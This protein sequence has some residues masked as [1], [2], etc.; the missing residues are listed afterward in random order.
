MYSRE[1]SCSVIVTFDI[2][3]NE[4]KLLNG[5]KV[6]RKLVLT[7]KITLYKFTGRL[8][9]TDIVIDS[10]GYSND[11]CTIILKDNNSTEHE[12]TMRVGTAYVKINK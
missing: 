6:V 9:N 8:S 10:K 2:G 3:K 5:I 1:N 4:I 7:N 11:A 12:I